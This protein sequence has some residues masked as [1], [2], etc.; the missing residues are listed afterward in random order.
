[1]GSPGSRPC[2]GH[3]SRLAEAVAIW[4]TGHRNFWGKWHNSCF[5][6][7]LISVFRVGWGSRE[8]WGQDQRCRK[9]VINF[10]NLRDK[11]CQGQL[12]NL[13]ELY[14]KQAVGSPRYML[15]WPGAVAEAVVVWREFHGHAV[16]EA[17]LVR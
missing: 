5:G 2:R 7:L 16:L 14:L 1:M 11:L 15:Y 8:S 3:I 17:N 10:C 4:G 12:D 6:R 13:L 9:G